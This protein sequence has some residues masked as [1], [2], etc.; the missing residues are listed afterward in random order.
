M[1]KSDKKKASKKREVSKDSKRLK[2]GKNAKGGKAPKNTKSIKNRKTNNAKTKN[3]GDIHD[4]TERL[5]TPVH[6]DVWVD[7]RCP[8]AWLTSRWLLQVERVRPVKVAFHVMSLAVLNQGRDLP[9]DYLRGLDTAWAPVRVALAV[10]EQYG[11]EQLAAFYTAVGTR[12]H[13][14]GHEL[15]RATLE[16]AL[17]DIGLATAIADAGDTGDNDDA[18]R[19]SHHAGIDLVGADVGTPVVKIGDAAIFGPVLSPVPQGEEAGL[20]FD[21]VQQ[22][23]SAPCFFELKRTRTAP[24]IF[25]Q[26]GARLGD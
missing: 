12:V 26:P 5:H 21:A 13:V 8:W 22:L 11:Q 2:G 18:L 14:Q 6:V 25:D 4:T 15:D 19:A 23:T 17:A 3:A 20:L 10:E 24:P 16:A 9:D 1:A 7:P